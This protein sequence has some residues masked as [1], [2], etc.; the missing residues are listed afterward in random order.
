MWKVWP[1]RWISWLTGA[2]YLTEINQEEKNL[3][4][5]EVQGIHF[6]DAMSSCWEVV[7]V[8]L[9]AVVT[10]AAMQ[11]AKTRWLIVGDQ[12][13]L[14]PVPGVLEADSL[15]K[16]TAWPGITSLYGGSPPS[17]IT[18]DSTLCHPWGRLLEGPSISRAPCGIHWGLGLDCITIHLSHLAPFAPLQVYGCCFQECTPETFL[19]SRLHLRVCFPGNQFAYI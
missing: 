15:L 11:A 5:Q 19:P 1:P 2:L 3:F 9:A 12:A 7:W 14:P 10:G 13:P 18:G 17:I 8:M 6:S 4:C 16:G